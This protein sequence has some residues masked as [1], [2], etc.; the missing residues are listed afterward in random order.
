[1][2]DFIGCNINVELDGDDPSKPQ[3]HVSLEKVSD[4]SVFVIDAW[5]R[6]EST[7]QYRTRSRQ[8]LKDTFCASY[9]STLSCAG[10]LDDRSEG[11]T[12]H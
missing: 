1:M 4:S 10:Q 2:V 6:V 5:T 3:H 8:V 9:F 7:T 11:Y 12:D